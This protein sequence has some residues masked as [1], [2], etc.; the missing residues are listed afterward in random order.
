MTASSTL[1]N[2]PRKICGPT[3]C[4]PLYRG[5]TNE[6]M[7]VSSDGWKDRF[8]IVDVGDETVLIDVAAPADKL[9]EVLP[10]TQK[11]LDSVE[12]IEENS[13]PS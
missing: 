12:W 9:D 11:I 13:G 3:P 2:Y 5:S 4:V 8:A 7:I 1:E 6:S 10:K